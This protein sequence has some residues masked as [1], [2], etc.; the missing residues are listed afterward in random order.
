MLFST[1]LGGAMLADASASTNNATSAAVL[2]TAAAT[3]QHAEPAK[4]HDA[5]VPAT[6]LVL[7]PAAAQLAHRWEQWLHA[8]DEP[9]PRHGRQR[10]PG[11]A[12]LRRWYRPRSRQ[13]PAEHGDAGGHA[14]PRR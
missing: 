13:Q 14:A 3:T 1:R 8:H 12:R 7:Q 6:K 9:R 2:A 5:I 4:R 10:T 11:L